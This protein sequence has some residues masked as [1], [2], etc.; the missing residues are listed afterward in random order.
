[1]HSERLCNKRQSLVGSFALAET[2]IVAVPCGGSCLETAFRLHKRDG[3]CRRSAE[4]NG[5]LCVGNAGAAERKREN[6]KSKVFSL[7]RY[8]I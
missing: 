7:L 5:G 1:M 3:K 8:N 6:V 4:S 2:R